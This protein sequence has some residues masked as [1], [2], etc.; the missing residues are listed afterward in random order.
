MAQVA[1]ARILTCGHFI[2]S[3][4]LRSGPPQVLASRAEVTAPTKCS[5]MES[6][7]PSSVAL[8]ESSKLSAA[9]LPGEDRER[10][11]DQCSTEHILAA[12]CSFCSGGRTAPADLHVW[13]P[14]IVCVVVS[15]QARFCGCTCGGVD[16]HEE[17]GNE[18]NS[19]HQTHRSLMDRRKSTWFTLCLWPWHGGRGHHLNDK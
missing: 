10:G 5:N 14:R 16:G 9:A 2:P 18:A 1:H 19:P 6:A 3:L 11:G 12:V 17:P 4:T 13:A 8:G 7:R 15:A